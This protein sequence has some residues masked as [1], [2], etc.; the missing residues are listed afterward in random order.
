M[1]DVSNVSSLDGK[2]VLRG[3]RKSNI[4][5]LVF[6][7]LNMYSLR[8]KFDMLSEM[9]KGFV[10]VSMISETKLADSFPGGQ[11]FIVDYHTPF[12]FDRIGNGHG[13]LL[14]IREDIQLKSSTVIFQHLKVFMLKLVFIKKKWLLNC[15]YNP[16]I[17]EICNHLDII[18]KTL[19]TY[20][21]KYENVVSLGNLNAG[22]E[23]IL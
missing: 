11:F 9:I 18:T 22:T 21:D 2:Q 1:E 7:Q 3:I 19:D 13:I 4:N 6:G 20:Y 10:D 16:H 8:N 23:E 12:R 5:T 14:Y 17:N 15:S